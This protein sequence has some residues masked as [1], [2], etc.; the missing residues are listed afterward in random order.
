MK[1]AALPPSALEELSFLAGHWRGERE[2]IVIEEMWLAPKGGVAQAT[3]RLVEAG[4]V[5]TI[6][7]IVVAAE[8]DRVVMRYNHFQPNYRTWEDDGPIE[9]TLTEAAHRRLIFTNL[10]A[11]PKHALE[12]GYASANDDALTSW[13]ISISADGVRN[14]HTFDFARV[15]QGA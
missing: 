7:L 6:E 12:M 13:V 5:G 3:V 14:R 8:R 2:E 15:A 10:A 9:L 4:K 1:T 11:T